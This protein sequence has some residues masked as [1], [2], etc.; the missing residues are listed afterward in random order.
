[1]ATI[2]PSTASSRGLRK[3][4]GIGLAVAVA[5]HAA[6]L[7]ALLFTPSR[8]EVVTP[9]ERI[10]VTI[11]DQAAETSTSPDPFKQASPDRGPTLGEAAPPPAAEPEPLPEPVPAP[12]VPQPAPRVVEPPRPA[13]RP[14]AKAP[15]PPR[16]A[17]KPAAKA[18]PPK[19]APKAPSPK[20]TQRAANPIDRIVARTPPAKSAPA[21][22]P[23]ARAP[24]AK[25]PAKAGTAPG[26]AATPPRKAGSSAFDDA[27]K[28]GTPGASAQSRD[29]GKPASAYSTTER[30]S[31][32]GALLRQV[33]PKWQGRVPEG[34][35][36]DKLVT[37]LSVELKP[38]G[39]LAR[40]PT[41]VRQEGIDD[42]NR[43]Q[44]ARHAEEAVR[45]VELAA[46][47][48]LPADDYEGWKKLPPLR[49]K[50][51]L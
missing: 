20:P 46:P 41:V 24:A 51:A 13:P 33:K 22:A 35:G 37:I 9:P 36:T 16:P 32:A 8:R 42:S 7:A 15:P 49:F 50:K 30:A 44:A 14:V 6:V 38:D 4:E 39:S 18:P 29:E 17:P 5:L 1:M 21:K 2:A 23:A 34:V 27:F 10:E 19:P 31:F 11:A 47:F 26:K 12:P 25:A 48:N 45:A 28:T 40:K 43:A 3:D